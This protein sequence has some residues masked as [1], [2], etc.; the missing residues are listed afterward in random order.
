M[1]EELQAEVDQLPQAGPQ[2]G[3]VLAGRGGPHH[4][5]PFHD[6][7][8]VGGATQWQAMHTADPRPAQFFFLAVC[9]DDDE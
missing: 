5:Y 4:P 3:S 2:E 1:W 8:Q 9:D 7:Q 6:G